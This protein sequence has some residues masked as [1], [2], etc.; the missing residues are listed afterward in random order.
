MNFSGKIDFY[1]ALKAGL[2][3]LVIFCLFSLF[4]SSSAADGK[5]KERAKP[6][7]PKG[8]VKKPTLRR[9]SGGKKSGEKA[10][11]LSSERLRAMRDVVSWLGLLAEKNP[12]ASSLEVILDW[13][14]FW[15]FLNWKRAI[16]GKAWRRW[17]ELERAL[18]IWFPAPLYRKLLRGELK[19]RWVGKYWKER[20][21][22]FKT[23]RQKG[24]KR[25]FI[26]AKAKLEPLNFVKNSK[27][28]RA[29]RMVFSAEIKLKR[30]EPRGIERALRYILGKFTQS[31]I[32]ATL[33]AG[34]QKYLARFPRGHSRDIL[35][36]LHS[37]FPKTAALLARYFEVKSVLE[38]LGK[39]GLYKLDLKYRW[40]IRALKEDYPSL[41]RRLLRKN[42]VFRAKTLFVVPKNRLRWLEWSYDRKG[43]EHRYRAVI[44]GEG[45][46]LCDANWRPVRGPWLPTR[47]GAVWDSH[48]SFQFLTPFLRASGR[49][50]SFRW[51]VRAVKGGESLS[52][53]MLP[54]PKIY[55][56]GGKFL[57]MFTKLF[58]AGGIE[59]LFRRFLRNLSK[60]DNGRGM[61]WVLTLRPQRGFSLLEFKF[62]LPIVPERVLTS[63]LKMASAA[64][65]PP[66]RGISRKKSKYPP[67]F[68]RIWNS[69]YSDLREAY[70]LLSSE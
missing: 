12:S 31:E 59:G 40:N 13:V 7:A 26:W 14:K 10:R 33:P 51:K 5:G 25:V 23:P 29:Y 46:W 61:R 17:R 58:I 41:A 63:L 18:A 6:A 54:S 3:G 2:N 64:S 4:P 50:F 57:R 1:R 32:A 28:R 69:I 34:H 36:W 68:Y 53:E 60:G 20:Y 62:V 67:I 70:L 43:L 16:S 47:P 35:I 38:P 24:E 19:L 15:I 8:E 66:N 30:L 9:E 65:S 27:R 42:R 44:S 49:N 11:P 56:K 37:R 55:L 45:F 48:F 52:I 21:L 22:Y 39:S